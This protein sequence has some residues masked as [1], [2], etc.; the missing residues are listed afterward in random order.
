MDNDTFEA[1]LYENGNID[2]QYN[3]MTVHN[4][5][6]CGMIGI[7]DSMGMDGLNPSSNCTLF[8]AQAAL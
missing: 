2:F 1:I 8:Q 5:F 3:T 7:E 6:S 4:P